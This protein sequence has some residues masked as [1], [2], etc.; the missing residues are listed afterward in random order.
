MYVGGKGL[1][2]C[3]SGKLIKYYEENVGKLSCQPF[4]L[5]HLPDKMLNMEILLSEFK[6]DLKTEHISTNNYKVFDEFKNENG[7]LFKKIA[8]V[9]ACQIDNDSGL[10]LISHETERPF[11]F[12]DK[13]YLFIDTKFILL[14]VELVNETYYLYIFANKK[15]IRDLIGILPEK[16]SSL[17]LKL[18]ELS[19]SN[20]GLSQLQQELGGDLTQFSLWNVTTRLKKLSGTGLELQKDDTFKD[21]KDKPTT[22]IYR[23]LYEIKNPFSDLT[24]LDKLTV[25]IVKDCFVHSY[26]NITYKTLL[27][28][29][30]ENI[31]PKTTAKVVVQHPL[32]AYDKLEVYDDFELDEEEL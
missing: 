31:L 14:K 29:I 21:L 32:S 23:Y 13:E 24:N 1:D 6:G 27:D 30:K 5:S 2:V 19:L 18:G 12:R 4:I 11:F 20:Q 22:E 28:F 10:I 25:S 16:L 17:G 7:E 9:D 15:S 8:V 26:H 3:E